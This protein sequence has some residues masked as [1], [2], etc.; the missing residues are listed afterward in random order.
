M[1]TDE[2]NKEDEAQNGSAVRDCPDSAGSV[3]PL[4]KAQ[5]I[6][7]TGFTGYAACSMSEIHEDVEKRLGRPV[8]THEFANEEVRKEMREAYRADFVAMCPKDSFSQN[9]EHGQS[10][11]K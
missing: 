4:T 11:R 7:I 9:T 8:W 2:S 5:A 3:Q 10:E 1:K 6:V